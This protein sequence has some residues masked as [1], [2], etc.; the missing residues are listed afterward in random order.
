MTAA[1]LNTIEGRIHLTTLLERTDRI[2]EEHTHALISAK[3]ESLAHGP[4][5]SILAG[6]RS[7]RFQRKLRRLERR[8]A[9]ILKLMRELGQ[10]RP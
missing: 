1:E 2:L 5:E 8:R 4:I 6:L 7:R 3:I 9:T 10:E